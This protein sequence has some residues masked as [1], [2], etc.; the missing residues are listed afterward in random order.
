MKI[1]QSVNQSINKSIDQSSKGALL[2]PIIRRHRPDLQDP[3]Q[4]ILHLFR[5]HGFLVSVLAQCRSMHLVGHFS[6]RSGRCKCWWLLRAR[7]Q[8]QILECFRLGSGFIFTQWRGRGGGGRVHAI[9]ILVLPIIIQVQVENP[10][11]LRRLLQEALIIFVVII[12]GL[13][14]GLEEEIHGR[15]RMRLFPWWWWWWWWWWTNFGL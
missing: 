2:N 6:C 12:P 3:P 9:C 10:T 7:V 13:Q 1:Y 4:I 14:S 8:Q 15:R 11:I 5:V